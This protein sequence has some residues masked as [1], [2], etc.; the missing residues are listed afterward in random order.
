[1]VTVSEKAA[2]E[3]QNKV[4]RS[5][6]SSL[7]PYAELTRIHRLLGFY[8]NTS[9]YFVGVAFSASI[10]TDI[11]VTTILHR[12]V[13]LSLWSF[14]LRCGGC[15]WND[16]ID[17]D[18]DR[19]IS[20][21]K[22][23]PLPR[24]AVSTR[25]AALFTVALFACGSSVLF[26]LPWQCT[27]E[28]LIIIFFALLYPFGKRFTDYPQVTLGNI[29]WAIPM[30]MHSL[31]V[32]PLDHVMPTVCMFLFVATVIIMVDVIYSCQDTEEDLKVG[33]KNMAVRFR[34]SIHIL[35]YVL[36]YMSVALLASAGLFTG[37]G[38]PFFIISVGGHFLGFGNLLKATQLGKSSGVETRAKT[39]CLLTS[40]F[41][42]VGFG[43]EYCVRWN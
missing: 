3:P 11:P 37:L 29:G 9:P 43:F 1:M 40:I 20:R 19:Q 8:L 41:W 6:P 26:F 4:L 10:A 30:T 22:S 25:D 34:D 15:V 24:G 2:A 38:L 18:L 21:T 23:R 12:I 42:V 7:V 14:F 35:A 17:L 5:L 27:I 32:D 28:A 39:Y 33:V 36:F 31:G 13:L 16:L